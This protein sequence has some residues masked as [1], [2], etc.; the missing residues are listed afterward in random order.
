MDG[1]VGLDTRGE[2]EILDGRLGVYS[3]QSPNASDPE[4]TYANE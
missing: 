2:K 4:N 1:H 3:I